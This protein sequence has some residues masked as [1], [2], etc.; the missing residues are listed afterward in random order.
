MLY[1]EIIDAFLGLDDCLEKYTDCS[2][3]FVVTADASGLMISSG[4]DSSKLSFNRI[5]LTRSQGLFSCY[6]VKR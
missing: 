6:F 4:S 1:D 3:L 2:V 5:A